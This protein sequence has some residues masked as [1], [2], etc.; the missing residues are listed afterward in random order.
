MNTNQTPGQAVDLQALQARV[1]ALED[2][3][4]ICRLKAG[5]PHHNDGGWA[6]KGPTHMGACAEDFVADGVWD[7]RP[8]APLAQGRDAIRRMMQEFRATPFVIHYVMNPLI[9]V[10]GDTASGKWHALITMTW[11]DGSDRW[12]LGGYDEKYV[13]TPHG[14][15]Y[16][17]MRFIVARSVPQDAGWGEITAA[18]VR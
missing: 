7:G 3:Q 13:R 8:L 12:V 2:I 11:P 16:Q 9:E 17:Y 6:E 10:D 5:Y 1:R 14:W 15:R 4:E 18:T